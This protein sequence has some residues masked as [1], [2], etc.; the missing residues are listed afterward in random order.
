MPQIAF[1]L[2]RFYCGAKA[3]YKRCYNM[4]LRLNNVELVYTSLI[5]VYVPAHLIDYARCTTLHVSTNKRKKVTS[6]R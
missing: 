5:D 1:E 2:G 3:I 4:Y 6:S